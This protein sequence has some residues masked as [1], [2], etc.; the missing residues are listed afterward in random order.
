MTYY[1]GD[2]GGGGVPSGSGFQGPGLPYMLG[3]V[4]V[5][6]KAPQKNTPT[7]PT[8]E[9]NSLSPWLGWTNN[10]INAAAYSAYE[11]GGSIRLIKGG[12]LSFQYYASAWA[13]GSKARITTYNLSKIGTGVGVGTSITGAVMGGINFALSDKSWGDYGQLSISLLS[14]GLTLG[15][16]TT[17][18]GIGIGVMDLAGGFNG[19]YNYLDANQQFYNNTGLI[20]VPNN[21]GLPVYI[22]LRKP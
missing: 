21:M 8:Y 22:K 18:I 20:M 10:G 14:A 17:P 2:Q 13:G 5:A 3:E 16:P 6:A 11:A 7:T 9:T 1:Q 15:G 19:F 4:T 12:N